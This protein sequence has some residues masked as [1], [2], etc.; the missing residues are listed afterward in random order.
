METRVK[1]DIYNDTL[2]RTSNPKGE[3]HKPIIDHSKN[4][5]LF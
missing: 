1:N 3:N 5:K 2:E 4:I